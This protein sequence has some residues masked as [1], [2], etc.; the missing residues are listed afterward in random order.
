M[1]RTQGLRTAPRI[2]LGG[3]RHPSAIRIAAHR[4]LPDEHRGERMSL[5]II[6]RLGGLITGILPC[7]LPVLPVICLPGG[8]QSARFDADPVPASRARPYLAIAGLVTSFTL[9]TLV[10]SL[11]LGLLHLPQD[12][13]R[14]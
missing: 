8:A 14:W 3:C 2:G 9:V 5:I 10:G 7:I 6:G 13:I 4:E 1:R 12:V 11:P